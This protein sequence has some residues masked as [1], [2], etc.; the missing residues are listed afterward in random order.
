MA[1]YR[2]GGGGDLTETTL[3]TNESPT[4]S[5]AAETDISLSQG[6]NNFDYIGVYF[7]VTTL[8]D[9]TYLVMCPTSVFDNAT[10]SSGFRLC[11]SNYTNSYTAARTIWRGSTSN[12][13]SLK[14]SAGYRI[15]S[16]STANSN[17]IPTKIVGLK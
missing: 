10:P 4:S 17:V 16:T 9:T 13:T 3:W 7:R 11:L 12:Y 8:I 6:Y 2:S 15:N 5:I 14:V 1:F